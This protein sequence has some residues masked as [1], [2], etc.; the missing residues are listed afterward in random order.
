MT[1]T[2]TSATHEDFSVATFI[3]DSSMPATYSY[4]LPSL[5]LPPYSSQFSVKIIGTGRSKA[6]SSSHNDGGLNKN[7]FQDDQTFPVARRGIMIEE[8][9]LD[10]LRSILKKV[11]IKAGNSG[12]LLVSSA[13]TNRPIEKTSKQ[14]H[15][16]AGALGVVMTV[17]FSSIMIVM[18]EFQV[19]LISPILGMIFI[20]FGVS[21]ALMDVADR[22]GRV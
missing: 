15:V 16:G 10:T 2:P 22:R 3:S 8:D 6:L 5:N 19:V 20:T 21:F 4:P 9:D 18:Y 13:P 17:L 1:S 11:E 12:G 7:F 14:L